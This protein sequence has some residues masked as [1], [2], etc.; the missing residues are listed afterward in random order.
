MI[1]RIINTN[2][3]RKYLFIM[4]L[5]VASILIITLISSP[6]MPWDIPVGVFY[7]ADAVILAIL[8]VLL[9]LFIYKIYIPISKLEDKMSEFIQQRDVVSS[10]SFSEPATMLEQ[11]DQFLE[12]QK[13]AIE[14]EHAQAIMTQKMKYA[15]LQNQI[16]PHFLY[17]TLENIRG[18][19]IVDD[20]FTIAEMTEA[21]ARFFRYN[22]S[23]D[24]GI[25]K[26]SQELENIQTY[27]Q[28]Q[29]YRFKDRFV[30][31]IYNHD[32]SDAIYHCRIPKMTLQP[33][34]ENAIFHG[35]ENKI[36]QGHIDIHIEAGEQRVTILVSDDGI[37]METAVLQKL[38]DRLRNVGR[39]IEW[40]E[41]KE[42][43][44]G[45]AMENVNNRIRLLYGN[46]YGIHV[47]STLGVGT[48]VEIA[49]P[50]ILE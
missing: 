32:D 46:D 45:I 9:I 48:E 47:S 6:V 40:V 26:L 8:A 18:Q 27:M 1:K 11:M 36:E 24:N 35:L 31:H 14:K 38:N 10:G 3:L 42:N 2:F 49:L 5:L 39:K 23:K 12:L 50:F 17:N 30:F 28:I 13:K 7:T 15:E 19:A 20:N 33:I 41:G 4:I 43:N 29:Q 21:L 34:V 37:G 44:N 16:N 22:I 25:V